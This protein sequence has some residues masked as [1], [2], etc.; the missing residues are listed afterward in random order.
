MRG[1]GEIRYTKERKDGWI[2]SPK[3]GG[4]VVLKRHK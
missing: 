1:E 2:K 4:V 3:R